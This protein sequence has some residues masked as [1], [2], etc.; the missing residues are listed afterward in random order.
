MRTNLSRFTVAFSDFA[1]ESVFGG[2]EIPMFPQAW[3]VGLYLEKYMQRYIPVE[4]I[5]LRCKVVATLREGTRWR[6]NWVI[7]RYVLLQL[8]S[9]CSCL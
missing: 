9:F 4:V 6:V 1:W 8:Q 5:R 3:Q 7:E 2:N